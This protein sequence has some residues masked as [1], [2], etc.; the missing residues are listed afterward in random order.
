MPS[1]H[2]PPGPRTGPARWVRGLGSA[3]AGLC[4]AASVLFAAPTAHAA[5][6]APQAQPAEPAADTDCRPDGLHQ[7]PGVDVPYC[8]VYDADG[9]EQLP[10]GLDRRVIGYFT[11]WRNGANDQPTYLVDDIPWDRISHINYAFGHVDGDNRLSVGPDGPDNPATGMTWDRP[12]LEPDPEFPYDGHFNQLNKFKKDHPGV[13]TLVAVG[14]WAETGGYFDPDGERVDSGGFYSMTTTSTGVNHEGIETFADSA[15]EFVREYGFDGLD[16]DYEYA[17]SNNGAGSPDDYWISDERRG[18]LWAGYEE[19]MRVLREKLDTASAE[20]GT[21]YQLTAAVPSSGWLLRGQEVHQV[22][23]YLDF[24]NMMTYDLHGTW[25]HFVGHNGALYDSGLDPELADVYGAYDGIGY[26]NADWAHHYFRGAMQAGRIN[27]GLP[28]YTRGWK[29]V[30]GGENGLWGT[31]ALPDQDQCQPGTGLTVPCGDGAD[32]IDNLWHDSDP[33]TGGAIAAGANPI[34]H[35]LN[36]EDGV[37]GDY[38]ADY[39]VDD[40]LVGTYERHWDETTRNE[41]WWNSTTNTFLSGDADRTTAAKAD[42]VAD[43]GLGGVMIWEMVG[44]YAYDA[45]AG[46]YVMGDTLITSLHERLSD[47]GPYGAAKA[48]TPAPEQVLD[49]DVDFGGFALGDNNYPITPDVTITN[50]SSGD[51]PGGSTI[52][53][54]YGTSAP[55]DMSDQSGMGLSHVQVG[56]DRGDNVG[57]L[58]G[59]FHRV[60]LTVPSWQSI[61]AG[62]SLDFTLSYRLPIA[63]PSNFRI[64]VGGTEYAITYD[65]PREGTLVDAPDTGDGGGDGGGGGD[66]VDCDAP[67]WVAGTTYTQGDTVT[68]GGAA[69]RAQWWTQDEPGTTGEWGAWEHLGT[70]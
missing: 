30:E 39:G 67:A 65:A 21:Y 70:C 15:V 14:G 58:D 33:V 41:W 6:Q 57:G 63:Q 60:E 31:A 27:L 35:V 10:N 47:A 36:L 61:P 23:R 38:A 2:H 54:D 34:W 66:P 12:G 37:V 59:D 17:T 16:I 19:L 22:V 5:P 50:N 69:Y 7:T 20:D 53:F 25:N 40:E 44:D 46:Q 52:T 68:H 45:D 29:D 64:G 18:H 42:Y 48:E 1:S 9:R 51:I 24:V 43:T 28:F 32:G 26:L 49:V 55:G 62:G 11:S 3:A 13:R 8:D 4:V 56:H